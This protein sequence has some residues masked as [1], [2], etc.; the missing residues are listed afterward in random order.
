MA[1]THH[2]IIRYA[3]WRK[4]LTFPQYR[5]LGDDA[6][7]VGRVHYESYV[8]VCAFLNMEVNLTKTFSSRKLVEFAKRF[9]YQNV[10][11]TPFP[12]GSVLSSKCSPVI[13]STALSN[14]LDK[15]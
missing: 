11:I 4:G 15:G 6:L 9:F 7:I 10:D 2:V 8:E 3:A 12:L 1:L 14:A 13:L 5:V